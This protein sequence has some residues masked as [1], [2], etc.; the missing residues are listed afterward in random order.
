MTASA[1]TY[2]TAVIVPVYKQSQ[3]LAEAVACALQDSESQIFVVSDGCPHDLTREMLRLLSLAHPDR[4]FAVHQ[5]NIGLSGARNTGIRLAL[6]INPEVE[7]IYPLDADNKLRDGTLARFRALMEACPDATWVYPDLEAFGSRSDVWSPPPFS[8]IRQIFQNQCDAGSLIRAGVFSKGFTFD[9]TMREGLE[10]FDFFSRLT[11]AGYIGVRAGLVGFQYRVKP[12]SMLTEANKITESIV[13]RMHRKNGIPSRNH[14]LLELENLDRPRFLF[15]DAHDGT[16]RMATNLRPSWSTFPSATL[17]E[18]ASFLVLHA[19]IVPELLGHLRLLAGIMFTMQER[20]AP[21]HAV[22][23][24]LVR[25]ESDDLIELVEIGRSENSR[26]VDDWGIV[27]S[28]GITGVDNYLVPNHIAV[29]L[30]L[31]VGRSHLT[32]ETC[33]QLMRTG[34]RIGSTPRLGQIPPLRIEAGKP[35]G[36]IGPFIKRM[37]WAKQSSQRRSVVFAVPWLGLGGVDACVLELARELASANFAVG[38]VI[39]DQPRIS[40]PPFQL[41]GFSSVSWVLPGSDHSRRMHEFVAAIAHADAVVNAHSGL[42]YDT[43][44]Q[45]GPELS[46]QHLAYLHVLDLDATG[47]PVG[48]PIT[49]AQSVGTVDYFLSISRQMADILESMDVPSA[50]ICL[51]PNAPI[52]RHLSREAVQSR[53]LDGPLRVLYAGRLDHQKGIERLAEVVRRTP[54]A[55][56]NFRIMGSAVMGGPLEHDL[57][58]LHPYLEPSTH[59]L[60]TL[61]R[62]YGGADVMLLPS[63]WEGV[64]LAILDAMASGCVVVATDVGAVSEVVRDGENGCLIPDGTDAE[65]ADAIIRKLAWLATHRSELVRMRDRAWADSQ[66]RTWKDTAR[67]LQELLDRAVVH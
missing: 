35:P 3:Y 15:I 48:W 42:C 26:S 52:V 11:L 7:F 17:S 14:D 27:M 30:E 37:P 8:R 55:T 12:V 45:F 28:Q 16:R 51:L 67:L 21:Y 43:F 58:V 54:E 47:H 53:D 34:L 22:G 25:A 65:I 64:P 20:V 6:S 1:M 36:D 61:S 59:D 40:I 2:S 49:A 62:A 41:T 19:T 5:P 4:V 56:A 24:R 32:E 66:G 60:G 57:A 23:L 9:E 38:L 29:G 46:T 50:K 44:T 31:R 33:F 63:R 13:R 18:T 10:D 39:T